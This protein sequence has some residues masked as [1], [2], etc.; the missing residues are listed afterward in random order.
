V[1]IKT[2]ALFFTFSAALAVQAVAQAEDSTLATEQMARIIINL[3]AK[4]SAD[5]KLTLDDIA[6]DTASTT[7]EYTLATSIMHMDKKIR[8]DDKPSVLKVMI[9]PSASQ[10]ERAL[11]KI[12]LKFN[13]KASDSA[14]TILGQ[15]T[16]Q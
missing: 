1:N 16:E 7:N 6:K 12:L 8:P 9:S 10:S 3:E 5:A 14:K 4:P 11:A 15:I 13:E 2:I